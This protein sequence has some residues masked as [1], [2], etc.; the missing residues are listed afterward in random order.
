MKTFK[1]STDCR[2]KPYADLSNRGLFWKSLVPFFKKTYTLFV[3]FK[4]KPLRKSVFHFK[5]KSQPNFSCKTCWKE[6]QFIFT[7]YLMNHIFQI[8]ALLIRIIECI[9]LN[10]LCKHMKKTRTSQAAILVLNW[11]KYNFSLWGSLKIPEVF[12]SFSNFYQIISYFLKPL[13]LIK[14]V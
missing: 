9:E 2:I 6:Q 14:N 4:M 13:H 11:I 1:I 5:N 3:G 10:W 12:V 8:S 7:A